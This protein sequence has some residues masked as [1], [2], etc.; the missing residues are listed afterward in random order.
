[1]PHPRWAHPARAVPITVGV[2]ALAASLA[3]LAPLADGSALAGPGGPRWPARS[4]PA[5]P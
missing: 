4:A 2:L 3:V 5:W 1:M